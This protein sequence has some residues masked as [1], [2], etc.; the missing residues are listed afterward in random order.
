DSASAMPVVMKSAVAGLMAPCTSRTRMGD[1]TCA[2][3]G[4]DS[5]T[6][7]QDRHSIRHLIILPPASP[8]L[9][10]QETQRN[11]AAASF[12]VSSRLRP[13]SGHG[14]VGDH[15]HRTAV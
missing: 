14:Y 9:A 4:M 3:T 10:V 15:A 1:G 13:G 2:W 12:K 11:A 6:M 8:S 7:S 5:P